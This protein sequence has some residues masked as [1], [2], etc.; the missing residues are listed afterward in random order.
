M[1]DAVMEIQVAGSAAGASAMV[2]YA[3]AIWN[4]E[5]ADKALEAACYTGL[6]VG[7]WPGECA[8]VQLKNCEPALA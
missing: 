7:G 6:K 4:G 2:S 3:V 1:F 8:Q 5:D